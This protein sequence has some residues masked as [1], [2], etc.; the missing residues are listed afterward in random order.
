MTSHAFLKWDQ[1]RKVNR[2]RQIACPI[3]RGNQIFVQAISFHVHSAQGQGGNSKFVGAW[4]WCNTMSH[5]LLQICYIYS[6][7]FHYSKYILLILFS[8]CNH[9]CKESVF[10]VLFNVLFLVLD[11]PL[12]APNTLLKHVI[13]GSIW[14]IVVGEGSWWGWGF[15]Q[16]WWLGFWSCW[17]LSLTA[18]FWIDFSVACFKR[19]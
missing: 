11:F 18:V 3:A 17:Y 15:S 7:K 10:N 4:K 1:F 13:E 12:G 2:L 6:T 16:D 5:L 19:V 14:R 8:T 9:G